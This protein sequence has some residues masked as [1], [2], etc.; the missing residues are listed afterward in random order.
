MRQLASAL[1]KV[2]HELFSVCGA[3]GRIAQTVELEGNLGG[4]AQ[5]LQQPRTDRD[6]LD[7]CQGLGRADQLDADLVEL[8]EPTLLRPL[9]TEHGPIIEQLEREMLDQPACH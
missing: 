4:D 9:V 8:A 2:D 6:N 1:L 3:A 7:V 5:S